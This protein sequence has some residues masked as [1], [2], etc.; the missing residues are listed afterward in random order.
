MWWDEVA[1]A[2][3]VD[4]VFFAVGIFDG[5]RSDSTLSPGGEDAVVVCVGDTTTGTFLWRDS[6]RRAALP[7]MAAAGGTCVVGK[8]SNCSCRIM[9][10]AS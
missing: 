10:T 5:G 1:C 6:R 8:G 4:T 9:S 2:A 3:V 7:I